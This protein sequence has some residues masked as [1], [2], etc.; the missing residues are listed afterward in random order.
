M[1]KR[2]KQEFVVDLAG[3]NRSRALHARLCRALPMPEG[4]G[5]NYDAL[6]DVLTEYG[7]V[8]RLVFR[9]ASAVPKL[10]RTVCADAVAATPGLEI[11]FAKAGA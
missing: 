2:K 11:V 4:Y 3:V 7:P 1:S 10:F 6:Y 8:W 9:N 5:R